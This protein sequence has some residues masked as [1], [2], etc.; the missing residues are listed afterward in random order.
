MSEDTASQ[1]FFEAKYRQ[2]G[3]PW[4]FATSAYEQTRYSAILS[5][6]GDRRF[7]RAFE[8]GCSIGVLTQCLA[9][10]CGQVEAIEISSTAAGRAQERCRL[11]SN[12]NVRQG[13]LPSDIPG[14]TFDLILFSEIG[15]YFQP[16]TLTALVT[17]LAHRLEAGGVL[18][19]AHWLGVSADHQL[20]GDQVHDLLSTIPGLRASFA[21]RHS[22]FRI[23]HWTKL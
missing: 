11:L 10:K 1:A 23:N 21:Q 17:Q 22:A 9:G 3:D 19:A 14:E 20:G 12:V 16:A 8:P 4:D 13:S 7:R 15:Y 2:N 6:L 18:L 5:S